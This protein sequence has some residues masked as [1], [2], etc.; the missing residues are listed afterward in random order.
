M[1]EIRKWIESFRILAGPV[2]D[3]SRSMVGPKQKSNQGGFL[4]ICPIRSD[5]NIKVIGS[6]SV[7]IGDEFDLA[8]CR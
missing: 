3:H 7:N 2:I 4:E 8:T 6:D 5:C 1:E